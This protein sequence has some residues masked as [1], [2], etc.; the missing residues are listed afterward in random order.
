MKTPTRWIAPVAA[1]LLVAAPAAIPAKEAMSVAAKSTTP[2]L[3][4]PRVLT[5]RVTKT[6]RLKYLLSLPPGY[7][8]SGET[9]PLV[10]FLHGAGERG[11][12]LE[13]VKMHGPPKQAA[14]GREFPFILV[15]PQ[16][17][18]ETWWQMEPL[19]ALLDEIQA[20]YRVD[21]ARVYVTG[22]SMGGYGTWELAMTQ[23]QR[24]AAAV[25]VCG[26]GRPWM[27]PLLKDMPVWAFHGAR[28]KV[29]L[30][31]ESE[32]MVAALKNAGGNAKLTIYPN[33]THDAWTATY[34]N[35]EVYEWMLAQRKPLPAKGGKK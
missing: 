34:N 17:P 1:L 15:C 8:K 5:K 24:F 20:K 23:P 7:R 10:L 35:P 22:I 13:K 14:Q 9:Y 6:L 31:R 3:L 27:A 19:I 30:P 28:D 21:P 4:R 33:A 25:P 2:T 29:V 16:C 12:D 26:G 18:D 11:Q 32:D